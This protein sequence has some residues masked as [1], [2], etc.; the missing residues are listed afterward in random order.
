MDPQSLIQSTSSLNNISRSFNGLA[1]GITRSSFLTRSIAK[2]VKTDNIG[3]KKLITSD[4][5]FFRRRRESFLRRK[6]EDQIEASSLC[7]FTY[8]A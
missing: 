7:C 1:A 6:R 3:K 5:N 4:G 2:T 8:K